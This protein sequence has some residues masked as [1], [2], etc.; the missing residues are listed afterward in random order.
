MKNSPRTQAERSATTRAALIRAGRKLFAEHGFAGVGT[1]TI[2]R[3][4]D[5][6]RGAL[7][8][9][10]SD[11]TGLFAAVLDELEG[12]TAQRVAAAAF[13]APGAEFVEIMN[14]SLLA[15]LDACEQPEVQRILLIDGPSVLGWSHWREICQ[16]HVLGM[17][18]GVLAQGMADG[19][20]RELPVKPLAHA[21]LA[22]ADEAALLVSAAEEPAA[23]RRDVI[24]VVEPFF[25]ALKR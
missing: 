13:A 10:F 17:I 2:V 24:A 23:S 21:L 3:A 16:K 8:H 25:E 9:H 1:D 6:S 4:A 12:E 11:K 14:R 22:V 15:W 19:A 20:I 18:E 5:V 7:Y